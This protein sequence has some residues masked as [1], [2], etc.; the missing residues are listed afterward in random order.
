MS[1]LIC[2]TILQSYTGKTETVARHQHIH[3]TTQDIRQNKNSSFCTTRI[4]TLDGATCSGKLLKKVQSFKTVL[5]IRV[6][7]WHF[8]WVTYS[9]ADGFPWNVYIWNW[10]FVTTFTKA[11]KWNLFWVMWLQLTPHNSTTIQFPPIY[12]HI[13]QLASS[14]QI[15]HLVLRA[16]YLTCL[17]LLEVI[18]L[19]ILGTEYNSNLWFI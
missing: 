3:G 7:Q 9:M 11:H 13:S 15:S 14:L 4:L 17:I 12:F 6:C 1:H 10:R 5:H 16:V 2:N 8:H 19:T 18:T